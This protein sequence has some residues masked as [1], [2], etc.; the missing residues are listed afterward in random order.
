MVPGIPGIRLSILKYATHEDFE[1][2]RKFGVI[3]SIQPEHLTSGSMESHAYLDDWD[4][5]VTLYVADRFIA[6]NM[7]QSI[8][9]GTDFPIVDSESDARPLQGRHPET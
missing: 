8:A 4:G 7:A 3:A 5:R 1:R 2:F 9:F 6:G